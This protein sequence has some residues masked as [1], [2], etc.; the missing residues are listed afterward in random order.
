MRKCKSVSSLMLR[1]RC[2]CHS[3]RV[4][5]LGVFLLGPFSFSGVAISESKVGSLLWEETLS[6]PFDT[7]FVTFLDFKVEAGEC[8]V[9]FVKMDSFG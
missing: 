8:I 2:N 9:K 7:T 3:S 5:L 1:I 4:I 6:R